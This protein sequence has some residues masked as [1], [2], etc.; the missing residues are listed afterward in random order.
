MKILTC[1]L[2]F[3]LSFFFFSQKLLAQV[4]VHPV[5]IAL[6][7]SQYIKSDT[8]KS[9]EDSS[10]ASGLAFSVY[11]S[12][13]QYSFFL[14]TQVTQLNGVQNFLD[15]NTAINSIFN[16]TNIEEQFGLKLKIFKKNMGLN[17][18]L[19][20]S[21]YYRFTQLNLK[22]YSKSDSYSQLKSIYQSSNTGYSFGMGAQYTYGSSGSSARY[23]LI[24]L[25]Y[26]KNNQ[27]IAEQKNF[28][29]S[30][31]ILSIGTGF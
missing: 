9:I 3:Y 20:G 19:N 30:S 8:Y 5:E 14:K 27:N 21:G 11:S 1:F 13:D 2:Y 23:V 31:Y 6:V 12:N 26:S 25:D 22:T 16:L 24:Q 28:D 29:L 10:L 15:N 4:E 7:G 18:Y 17:I